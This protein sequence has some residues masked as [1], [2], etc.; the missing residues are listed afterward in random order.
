MTYFWAENSSYLLVIFSTFFSA[1]MTLLTK[2]LEGG[3]HGMGPFQ[4]LFVRMAVSMIA[5]SLLLFFRKR[6][7]FPFGPKGITL[8]LLGRG[9]S[10]FL[11][12][13]GI[14]TAIQFL[15]LADATVITFL[16]PSLVAMLSA[17]F[18]RK[19][20]TRKEQIASL[21]ALVGVVFIA[22]PAMIFGDTPPS[23]PANAPPPVSAVTSDGHPM[24]QASLPMGEDA[25]AADRFK[26]TM[27]AVVSAVGGAGAFMAIREIGDRASILTT[28]N[29]FAGI[30][31][32]FTG[33]A[34]AIA[35]LLPHSPSELHFALPHDQT[36][37]IL[38]IAI[39]VCGFLTQLLLTAG[40]GGETKSNKA[41]AMVY[42]GM[43][44][45]AGFD[46]WVF[47]QE[48]YWSSFLGCALIV[49][50]AVWIVVQPKPED[51]VKPAAGD[52]EHAAG[53]WAEEAVDMLVELRNFES[54]PHSPQESPSRLRV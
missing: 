17:I 41:P 21:L 7:E 54:V 52:V 23:S 45:T 11:G 26:G 47:G 5:C 46:K 29:Y 30:C 19:P 14:W 40:I 2:L 9:A 13:C 43:L 10:G 20:F 53:E 39:T 48:M 44:W 34:L 18:M 24:T 33:M 49:G 4:I 27:L 36:Q 12:I 22:R 31:T 1:V 51:A 42:T 50:G 32:V 35:P 6:S 8:L 37:W 25:S 38:V 16:T 15:D 3:D 28:T